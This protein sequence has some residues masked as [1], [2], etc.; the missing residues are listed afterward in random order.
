[1]TMP[2]HVTSLICCGVFVKS[3]TCILRKSTQ[4][5]LPVRRHKK[6]EELVDTCRD[7]SVTNRSIFCSAAKK[8][9]FWYRRSLQICSCPVQKIFLEVKK[10]LERGYR[11]KINGTSLVCQRPGSETEIWHQLWGSHNQCGPLKYSGSP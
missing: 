2:L 5:I 10:I 1:M 6:Q 9:F 11:V 8:F 3:Y 7:A 4:Q